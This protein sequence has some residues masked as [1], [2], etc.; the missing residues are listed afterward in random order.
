MKI[1]QRWC[2]AKGLTANPLKTNVMVFTKKYRPE[3]IEPLKLEVKE[4]AFTCSVK[5][6]GVLLSPK[7]NWKQH[8]TERRQKLYSSV[9]VCWRAR[10]QI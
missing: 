9:R 8:V 4:I 7:L 1:T 10:G 3:P 2:K 5:Y 6:L